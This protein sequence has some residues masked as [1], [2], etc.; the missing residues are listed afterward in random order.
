MLAASATPADPSRESAG[1]I[2]RRCRQLAECLPSRR[3]KLGYWLSKGKEYLRQGVPKG[4]GHSDGWVAAPSPAA[5]SHLRSGSHRGKATASC[6][7]VVRIAARRTYATRVQ[8]SKNAQRL[9]RKNIKANAADARSRSDRSLGR[10]KARAAPALS[11]I[12]TVK[13]NGG[14]GRCA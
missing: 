2:S 8:Y 9:M 3:G 7:P 4:L 10:Q 6:A 11:K 13:R 14:Q 1:P 5:R 12:T